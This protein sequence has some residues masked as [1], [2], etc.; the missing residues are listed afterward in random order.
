MSIEYCDLAIDVKQAG[1]IVLQA[2]GSKLTFHIVVDG[3]KDPIEDPD[4]VNYVE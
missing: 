1:Y 3:I 4:V 2:P